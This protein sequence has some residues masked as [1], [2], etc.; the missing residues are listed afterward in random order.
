MLQAFETSGAWPRMLLIMARQKELAELETMGYG[1]PI[2]KTMNSDVPL[3]AE[4]LE[5]FA[6]VAPSVGLNDPD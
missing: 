6:G 5:Y 3:G 2:R 1:S 4:Q